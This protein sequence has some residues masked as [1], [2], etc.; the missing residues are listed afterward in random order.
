MRRIIAGIAVIGVAWLALAQ[1]QTLNRGVYEQGANTISGA[2]FFLNGL[3]I[4]TNAQVTVNASTQLVSVV[5]GVTNLLGLGAG[6]P[7]PW[8]NAVTDGGGN[9]LSNINILANS[10]TETQGLARLSVITNASGNYVFFAHLLNNGTTNW[11]ETVPSINAVSN[12]VNALW[13]A[14]A[15]TGTV[16][17]AL[18]L[19]GVALAGLVQTNSALDALR[20]NNGVNLTNLNL[21]GSGG[22]TNITGGG[23]WTLSS[24]VWTYAPT[25]ITTAVQSALDG[26]P[27]TNGVFALLFTN[28][29]LA[30]DATSVTITN[31]VP[32]YGYDIDFFG[33]SAAGSGNQYISLFSSDT[34][35]ATNYY[36]SVFFTAYIAGTA[37]TPGLGVP[38]AAAKCFHANGVGTYIQGSAKVRWNATQGLFFKSDN[39]YYR[40][41]T[42]TIAF[43]SFQTHQRG[44]ISGTFPTF[45]LLQHSTASGMKSGSVIRVTMLPNP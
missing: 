21:V 8:T 12:T 1:G 36:Q 2:K 16:A 44:A 26:K 5:N 43:H 34:S 15:A 23:T 30:A 39:N 37:Y 20:L 32:G 29:V 13:W 22:S 41:D 3:W 7:N 9:I 11:S 18:T 33:A 6:T 14:N 10:I 38:E 19:D 31:L 17:N 24:G 25:G 42:N 28:I 4:G 40:T 35:V 45:L 27:N